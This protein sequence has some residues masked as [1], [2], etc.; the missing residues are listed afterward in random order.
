MDA[1]GGEVEELRISVVCNCEAH[2]IVVVS[3]IGALIE[4]L[5]RVLWLIE[6]LSVH[7]LVKNLNLYSK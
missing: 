5:V 3:L 7:S 2:Y 1:Y 6:T 4:C